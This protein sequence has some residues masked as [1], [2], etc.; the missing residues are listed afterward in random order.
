MKLGF[1]TKLEDLSKK[2]GMDVPTN[3]ISK[4]SGTSLDTECFV[5]QKFSSELQ[6]FLINYVYN[7]NSYY[8]LNG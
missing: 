2:R 6:V 5:K 4:L 7:T 3:V 1:S 8:N